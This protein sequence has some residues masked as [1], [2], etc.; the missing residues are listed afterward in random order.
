MARFGAVLRFR[1]M[2]ERGLCLRP[3]AS[4]GEAQMEHYAGLDVSVEETSLCI[5]DDAGRIVREAKIASE[6]EALLA[7]LSNPDLPLQADRTRSW[8]TVAMARRR[9]NPAA[10]R[11]RSRPPD[12]GPTGMAFGSVIVATMAVAPTRPIPGMLLSRL[13]ALS[14][15][16]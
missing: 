8:T 3:Q 10:V 12:R 11:A 16:C 14:E 9:S 7:V 4:E 5:V 13:L 1:L 6:P 2:M 15:R